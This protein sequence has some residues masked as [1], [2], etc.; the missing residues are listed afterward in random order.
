MTNISGRLF[1]HGVQLTVRGMRFTSDHL[2]CLL[3]LRSQVFCHI[4]NPSADFILLDHEFRIVT[5]N[6]FRDHGD[7]IISLVDP[8]AVDFAQL[9]ITGQNPSI[10]LPNINLG[11]IVI[12]PGSLAK[13]FP[14]AGGS[15]FPG[16][17]P[18]RFDPDCVLMNDSVQFGVPHLDLGVR[19]AFDILGQP[20]CGILDIMPRSGFQINDL[21]PGLFL[22]NNKFI[23]VPVNGIGDDRY[24]LIRLVDGGPVD[25]RP[26]LVAGQ[27]PL[28]V[29]TDIDLGTVVIRPGVFSQCS[30]GADRSALPGI[31]LVRLDPDGLLRYFRA[32]IIR[33]VSKLNKSLRSALDDLTNAFSR[34]VHVIS[35]SGFDVDDLCVDAGSSL[36]HI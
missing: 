10:V 21:L 17:N 5:V 1:N 19:R 36:M 9:I 29:L 14:A 23:I 12:C 22:R 16:G 31:N 30:P 35:Q 3:D 33:W 8:G 27:N 32:L 11:T 25:L 6:R 13:R 24:L 20:L 2:R 26:L 18:I 4:L 7:M 28:A 34:L 15:I